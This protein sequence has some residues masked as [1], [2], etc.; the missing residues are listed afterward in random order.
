[1]FGIDQS[2]DAIETHANLE[3]LIDPEQGRQ[4]TGIGETTTFLTLA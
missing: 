4:G 3:F 1:M 2:H